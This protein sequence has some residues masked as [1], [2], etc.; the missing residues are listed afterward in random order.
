MKF[1]LEWVHMVRYDLIL[2]LDGALW[3]RIISKPLLIPNKFMKG[4]KM[5][6]NRFEEVQRFNSNRH[7]LGAALIAARVL[8][9]Y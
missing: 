8:A 1:D 4:P 5:T 3:L 9:T 7:T 6:Q 2:R